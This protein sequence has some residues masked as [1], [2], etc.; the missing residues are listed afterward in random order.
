M[1]PSPELIRSAKSGDKDALT[2]LII[3]STPLLKRVVAPFNIIGTD[4][5]DLLQEATLA[6]IKAVDKYD[7][8]AGQSFST[9]LYAVARQRIIDVLKH[10][11]N[12][13]HALISQTVSIDS[14]VDGDDDRRLDPED[15]SKDIVESYIDRERD[16]LFHRVADEILTKREK[17]VLELYL[18]GKSYK[19]MATELSVSVKT[20]DNTLSNVKKKLREKKE[21]FD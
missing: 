3:D 21:L 18:I 13:K 7:E 16:D 1:N 12:S 20:I 5:E 11:N 14:P 10:A 19:E 9:F 2:R 4:K 17:Q 15:D 6:L 8:H